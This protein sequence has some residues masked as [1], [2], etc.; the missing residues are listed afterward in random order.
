MRGKATSR[1]IPQAPASL[2]KTCSR[3][4]RNAVPEIRNL[5]NPFHKLDYRLFSMIVLISSG[6]RIRK[7]ATITS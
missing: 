1:D 6:I 3:H 4:H 7:H 5:A 2:L